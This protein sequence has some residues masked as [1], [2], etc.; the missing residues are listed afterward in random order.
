VKEDDITVI[1]KNSKKMK[2]SKLPP[3]SFENGPPKIVNKFVSMPE[4]PGL[5]KYWIFK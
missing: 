1:K 4:Q 2:M 3:T 5:I